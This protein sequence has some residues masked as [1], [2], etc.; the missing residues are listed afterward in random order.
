MACAPFDSEFPYI[1]YGRAASVG[2]HAP[3]PHFTQSIRR[4]SDALQDSG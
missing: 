4:Q 1:G 2:R 3:G